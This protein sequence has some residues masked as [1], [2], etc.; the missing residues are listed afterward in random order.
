M[1][2]TSLAETP[3]DSGA[4]EPS[5]PMRILII[6]DNE[7]D[8]QRLLR[9]IG[10]TGLSFEATQ[11]DCLD[12]MA[13]FLDKTKFD[14][15]FIDYFLAGD[16]GLDA[17]EILTSHR[18]Q[19]GAAAIMLAGEGQISIAVEAMR[20]GCS[21]YMTKAMMN[22]DTLQKSVATALER[23]MMAAA[24]NDQQ[25]A[26][27]DVEASIRA[28]ANASTAEMRGILSATLRRARKLRSYRSQSNVAYSIDL[29]A[30]ETD[31]DRLW[32]ALPEIKSAPKV[33]GSVKQHAVSS[34]T[35]H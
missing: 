7:L 35:Q 6:D 28:Y 33:Q 9:L 14:I 10:Q 20:C 29:N 34:D 13:P 5:R 11:V 31:I 19:K 4:A 12:Q 21:D 23:R 25:R 3:F 26:H 8:R 18:K 27:E 32:E 24:M 1:L 17:L 16:T 22:V 2:E 30:L 15:V